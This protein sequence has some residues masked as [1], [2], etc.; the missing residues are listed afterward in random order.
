LA[1]H[2]QVIGEAAQDCVEDSPFDEGLSGGSADEFL[3]QRL[4]TGPAIWFELFLWPESFSSP[5]SVTF[6]ILRLESEIGKSAFKVT[7]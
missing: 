1:A 7:P 2:L 5:A 6:A 3:C 4:Q